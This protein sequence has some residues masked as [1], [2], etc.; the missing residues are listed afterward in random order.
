MTFLENVA[1]NK[2][3][4]SFEL[5]TRNLQDDSSEPFFHT[6]DLK[7]HGEPSYIINQLL[8]L[9]AELERRIK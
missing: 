9:A 1:A 3:C 2:Q 5:S 6:L 4:S 7:V 8:H